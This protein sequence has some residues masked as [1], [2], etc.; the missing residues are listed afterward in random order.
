MKGYSQSTEGRDI[1]T[2]MRYFAR[3][4]TGRSGSHQCGR[5]TESVGVKTC[6]K[7]KN[8][9]TQTL[10][11]GRS[12]LSKRL[13]RPSLPH[14]I[15][16]SGISVLTYAGI[17]AP[18]SPLP[19]GGGK[20]P[21]RI[22]KLKCLLQRG[23]SLIWGGCSKKCSDNPAHGKGLCSRSTSVAIIRYPTAAGYGTRVSQI[24]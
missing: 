8:A 4:V 10:I 13:L 18:P 11:D 22:R 15:P 5:K 24:P 21:I 2:E 23:V 1:C 6:R 19:R 3:N 7:V 17:I 20:K 9:K 12:A 16:L 14:L